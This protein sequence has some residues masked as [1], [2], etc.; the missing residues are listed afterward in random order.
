MILLGNVL[1]NNCCVTDFCRCNRVR[2]HFG[3]ALS[4][5]E[6][7]SAKLS[8]GVPNVVKAESLPRLNSR[9]SRAELLGLANR[10]GSDGGDAHRVL[11]GSHRNH[12]GETTKGKSS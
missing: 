3:G 12:R 7:L 2:A 10:Q 1:T 6:F 4:V 8:K 9:S 11:F 5:V